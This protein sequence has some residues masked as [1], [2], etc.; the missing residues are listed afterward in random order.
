[1]DVHRDRHT[2]RETKEQTDRQGGEQRQINEQGDILK[3]CL[4]T[5]VLWG[6]NKLIDSIIATSVA[7]F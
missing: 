1:M 4:K 5:K 6:T 3:Y 2:D 7:Q